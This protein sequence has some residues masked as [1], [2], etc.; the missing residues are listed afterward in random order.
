[1]VGEKA[2]FHLTFVTQQE[3][4]EWL[5]AFKSLGTTPSITVEDTE[6]L[7]N[8][9]DSLPRVCFQQLNAIDSFLRVLC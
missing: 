3:G 8:P 5:E 6:P 4:N 1:M 7:E 2:P 9:L